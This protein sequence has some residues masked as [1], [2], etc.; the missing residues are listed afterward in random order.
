MIGV[1]KLLVL[2]RSASRRSNTLFPGKSTVCST[3]SS[4]DFLLLR[5][6]GFFFTTFVTG[7]SEKPL[8]VLILQ[9]YLLREL[10]N[11]LWLWY[12]R[13]HASDYRVPDFFYSR[14]TLQYLSLS[15]L[16]NNLSKFTIYVPEAIKVCWWRNSSGSKKCSRAKIVCRAW[17]EKND[18][19]PDG[20]IYLQKTLVWRFPLHI[21][22]S[23]IGGKT[24]LSNACTLI[25]LKIAELI[26]FHNIDMPKP[27]PFQEKRRNAKRVLG[28]AEMTL[29]MAGGKEPHHEYKWIMV[30]SGDAFV[31]KLQD[32]EV[33]IKNN[34]N[35]PM[36]LPV[37]NCHENFII[38]HFRSVRQVSSTAL[39]ME[40]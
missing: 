40:S 14:A 26:H 7:L 33:D 12:P 10:N 36:N 31:R 34:E 16:Y 1:A 8:L 35:M 29:R 19:A 5:F 13:R 23:S 9:S 28:G 21:S 32:L 18:K 3:S 38:I 27:L 25:A 39:W 17:G 11:E 24:N 30:N 22:Q 15:N 20:K 37:R 2:S 4:S 6:T